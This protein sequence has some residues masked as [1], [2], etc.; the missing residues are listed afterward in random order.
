MKYHVELSNVSVNVDISSLN[1]LFEIFN[2]LTIR[3]LYIDKLLFQ[4]K[5]YTNKNMFEFQSML[6][7]V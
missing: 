7:I 1:M 2:Y 6:K 3:I 5:I 4:I